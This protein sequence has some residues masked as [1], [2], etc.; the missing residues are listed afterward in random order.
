VSD[1]RHKARLCP[2]RFGLHRQSLHRDTI[3]EVFTFDYV[4]VNEDAVFQ[5]GVGSDSKCHP[6][7]DGP[8]QELVLLEAEPRSD[9]IAT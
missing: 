4:F 7:S 2:L 5:P 1:Y 6:G 9:W 3:S 8:L